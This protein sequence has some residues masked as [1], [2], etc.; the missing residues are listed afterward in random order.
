[1]NDMRPFPQAILFDLDAK[2]P[3]VP[4]DSRGQRIRGYAVVAAWLPALNHSEISRQFTA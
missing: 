3:T 2:L 4:R 1:M